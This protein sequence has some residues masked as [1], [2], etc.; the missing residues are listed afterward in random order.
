MGRLGTYLEPQPVDDCLEVLEGLLLAGNAV[1]PLVAAAAEL[2]K[3]LWEGAEA[4]TV[5]GP[6]MWPA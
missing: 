6:A 3:Q 2:I 1:P 4:D 5:R